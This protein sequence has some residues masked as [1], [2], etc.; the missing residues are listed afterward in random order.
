MPVCGPNRCARS[1]TREID[2]IALVMPARSRAGSLST[3]AWRM[4]YSMLWL[5]TARSA[6]QPGGGVAACRSTS[7]KKSQVTV[8]TRC[9]TL[10]G[11]TTA[12]RSVVVAVTAS[13]AA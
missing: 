8:V 11:S 4:P 10:S 13:G 1:V 3:I 12:A 7:S 5:F 9:C 6:G 2:G